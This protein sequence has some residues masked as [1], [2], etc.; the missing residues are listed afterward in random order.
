MVPAVGGQLPASS[1]PHDPAPPLGGP[2]SPPDWVLALLS[3]CGGPSWAWAPEMEAQVPLGD[4]CDGGDRRW[5][6]L[7]SGARGVAAACPEGPPHS[8]PLE[9]RPATS[10]PSARQGSRRPHWLPEG[11]S[12]GVGQSGLLGLRGRGSPGGRSRSPLRGGCTPWEGT[13]FSSGPRGDVLQ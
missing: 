4:A 1:G 2:P 13:G 3:L 7:A 8:A 10:L 6:L 11:P 12:V 5:G 9:G